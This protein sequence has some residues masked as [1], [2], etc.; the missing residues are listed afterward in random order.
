VVV[1]IPIVLLVALAG[2]LLV[3]TS[4]RREQR[5]AGLSREARRSDKASLVLSAG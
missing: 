4:R 2:V 5:A 1:V 3:G